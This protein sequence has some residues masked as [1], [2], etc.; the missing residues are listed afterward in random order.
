MEQAKTQEIDFEDTMRVKAAFA[1]PNTD[2]S[3]KAQRTIKRKSPKIE[4]FF[5]FLEHDLRM[6]V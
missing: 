3:R 2:V 5:A 1:A 4:Q 6:V